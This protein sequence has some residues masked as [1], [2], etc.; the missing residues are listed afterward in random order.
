MAT[1]KKLHAKC[2]TI[3]FDEF[4]WNLLIFVVN[5]LLSVYNQF[6]IVLEFLSAQQVPII[7]EFMFFFEF[8]LRDEEIQHN[9]CC[10]AYDIAIWRYYGHGN[11]I[12]WLFLE[13]WN[14]SWICTRNI[15]SM[16]LY[17]CLLKWLL[18]R[19]HISYMN[20]LMLSS[21]SRYLFKYL[22]PTMHNN[23][24]SNDSLLSYRLK[25]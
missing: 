4:V 2:W 18:I 24:T 8:Y 16:R 5:E 12:F 21:R 23:S 15:W 20:P 7:S 1:R 14:L 17:V 9:V 10:I 25:T 19:Q 11:D 3:F 13:F 6:E 22:F